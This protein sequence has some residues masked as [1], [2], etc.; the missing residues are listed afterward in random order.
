M[1]F[2]KKLFDTKNV[3]TK[4][5]PTDHNVISLQDKAHEILGVKRDDEI[6]GLP[7]YYYEVHNHHELF[8]LGKMYF[9]DMQAGVKCFAIGSLGYKT[10]QQRAILGL[11]SFFDLQKNLKVGIVSDNLYRG[12]FK[13]VVQHCQLVPEFIPGSNLKIDIHQF[14]GHFDFI[15]MNDILL[16][17]DEE[18]KSF[19]S[20]LDKFIASHDLVFF[21]VPDLGRIKRKFYHYRPLLSYFE[22]LSIVVVK[23]MSDSTYLNEIIDFYEGHGIN[24]KGVVI[25][26]KS[27]AGSELHE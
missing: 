26:S 11:T 15:D 25:D 13:N 14:A 27:G 21:D 16:L 1:L 3:L 8:H 2:R 9:E 17:S 12:V 23:K 6:D 10:S 19:Y 4:K 20:I 5:V 22:S 24:L 18:P 7:S